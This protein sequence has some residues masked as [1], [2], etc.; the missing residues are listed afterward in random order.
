M[1]LWTDPTT[2]LAL[3]YDDA[4]TGPVVVLLH[5]FPFDRAMWAPQFAELSKTH[6]AIVPDTFGFGET[7]LPA[8]PWSMDAMAELLNRFFSGLGLAEPFVLGGLSMGGYIA[9]AFAKK[10]PKRLR[11]LILADTRADADGKEAKAKRS[12]AM[13]LVR[14]QGVGPFLEGM[15]PRVL[16]DATRNAKPEVVDAIREIA[17][18]QKPEAVIA[19]LAALRDRPDSIKD[20]P[21]FDFPVQVIVGEEDATTPMELAETMA[22]YLPNVTFESLPNAGHLSN[23]ETPD[24]FTSAVLR[25]LGDLDVKD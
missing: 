17:L 15:L 24:A 14:G 5:P 23:R 18:R 4:G 16:C 22:D 13:E 12:E 21:F 19:A 7:G 1:P 11:G 9:L 10:F 3:G 20:L 25:W 6:R 2:G 8:K